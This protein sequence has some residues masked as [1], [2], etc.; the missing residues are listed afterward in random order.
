MT[1]DTRN[2]LL[3][4][5]AAVVSSL[6]VHAPFWFDDAS[7]PARYWDGPNYLYI[8]QTLYDIPADH[9]LAAYDTT[10]A[11][12]A[13][14]LPLYPL[15]IRL[16][17]FIGYPA[18]MLASTIL[19][20]VLATLTFYRLLVESKVVGDPLWSALVSLF[21]PARW[22]VYHSV[23]AT[24]APFLFFVFASML[25]YLRGN[26]VMSFL[27]GGVAGMTRIIGILLGA[28]YLA[29]LCRERKWSKI[30]LLTL[31]AVPLLAVFTFYRW[32]FGNFFVYFDWNSALL[33]LRPLEILSYYADTGDARSAE[34]YALMYFVYGLGVIMLWR[35]PLFFTYA[36]VIYVA[37]LFMYHDDLSRLMIPI[38]P[39]A[40]V[41]AY[42]RI[43]D[44]K[45]FKIAGLLLLV[46]T[47]QYAWRILP[48]NVVE[49]DIY[50]NLTGPR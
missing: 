39:F 24:E 31:V 32:R 50:E 41:V 44:T 20:T 12:F 34:L 18:A 38:A 45:A 11:Y 37:N 4:A 28:V 23:G 8:A 2:Y 19:F 22:L 17:S 27:L 3:L 29:M 9:P 35:A 16:L 1:T 6:A 43:I 47:Y 42:D 30:P 46:V 10:P 25:C 21:L 40:L 7:V 15:V 13:C 14:H 26:Y 48:T 33:S 49:K 36:A 5:V